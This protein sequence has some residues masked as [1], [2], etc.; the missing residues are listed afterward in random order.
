MNSL[1]LSELDFLRRTQLKGSAKVVSSL[2]WWVPQGPFCSLG[3]IWKSKKQRLIN[4]AL[5]HQ[6]K[7]NSNK[8]GSSIAA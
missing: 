2:K 1:L 4:T 8:L 7:V 3:R 5:A 6:K